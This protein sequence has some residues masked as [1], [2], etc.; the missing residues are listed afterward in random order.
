VQAKLD[1]TRWPRPAIFDW[2]QRHGRIDA[3]EMHRTFNCGLGMVLIVARGDVKAA[4][5]VFKEHGVDAFEVGA[6]VKRR[7][8]EPQTVV[9]QGE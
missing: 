7:E 2:L 1:S 5:D 9:V 6:I 4:L 3:T 8:G